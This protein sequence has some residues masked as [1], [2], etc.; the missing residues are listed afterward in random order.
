MIIMAKDA[1]VLGMW[2]YGCDWDVTRIRA[3]DVMGVRFWP[4]PARDPTAAGT[5]SDSVH[6]DDTEPNLT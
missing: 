3:G 4:P 2:G 6:L 5:L 1:L